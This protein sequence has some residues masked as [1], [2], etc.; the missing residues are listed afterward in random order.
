MSLTAEQLSKSG[1][2]SS[3]LDGIIKDQLLI[4]D[5]G[6]QQQEKSWGR[7]VY[8]CD[9]ITNIALPGMDKKDAQRIIY[10]AIVRSLQERGFR[11][12]LLLE[13]EQTVIYIEWISNLDPA[14]IRAMTNV[15]KAVRIAAKDV[16]PYLKNTPPAAES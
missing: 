13:P 8:A 14:E 1:A 2:R 4:I 15:I 12:R 7:N 6:L 9:L 10:A 5:K 11:V 3:D 16:E